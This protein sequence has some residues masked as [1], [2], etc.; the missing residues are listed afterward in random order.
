MHKLVTLTL[1]TLLTFNSTDWQTYEND[2]TNNLWALG[3]VACCIAWLIVPVLV[4][5]EANETT[6]TEPSDE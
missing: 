5:R 2:F 3:F 1:A 4:L 6:N